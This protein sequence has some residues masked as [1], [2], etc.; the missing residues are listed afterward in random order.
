MD[1]LPMP[2][3]RQE[4][5]SARDPVPQKRRVWALALKQCRV[6][7]RYDSL[8]RGSADLRRTQRV[9]T[10]S[11]PRGGNDRDTMSPDGFARSRVGS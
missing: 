8:D 7:D 9:R 4:A 3:V 5:S 2:S 6:P 1:P 10:T 11:Y